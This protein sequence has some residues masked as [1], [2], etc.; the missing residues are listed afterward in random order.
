[1]A[2]EY[3]NISDKRL[4]HQWSLHLWFLP[5]DDDCL[6]ESLRKFQ[7]LSVTA[8]TGVG[9]FPCSLQTWGHPLCQWPILFQAEHSVWSQAGTYFLSI[10][11]SS[12]QDTQT[13]IFSFSWER[14][15]GSTFDMTKRWVGEGN[16]TL[17]QSSCLENPMDG[18]AWQAA[19]HGVAKSWTRLSNF[20]LTFQRWVR[21]CQDSC[22]KPGLTS[23]LP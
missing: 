11:Y 6:L 23:S 12:V 18:G 2:S 4:S 3:K 10:P 14:S 1:M 16:G 22:Q 15:S 13:E 17:L 7:V 19:V 20:T 21:S 8:V 5:Y 9:E